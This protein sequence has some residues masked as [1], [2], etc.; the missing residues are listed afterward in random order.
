MAG[1]QQSLRPQTQIAPT[2]QARFETKKP[3]V[4]AVVFGLDD[5]LITHSY[6]T[7]TPPRLRDADIPDLLTELRDNGLRLFVASGY[8]PA[9]APGQDNP[10]LIKLLTDKGYTCTGSVTEGEHWKTGYSRPNLEDPE[11]SGATLLIPSATSPGN[12][13]L[14]KH[15]LME[16]LGI[17]PYLFEAI[18]SFPHERQS[19]M[20]P[21]VRSKIEIYERVRADTGISSERI[22]VVSDKEDERK[23]VE[24]IGIR[25]VHVK[26]ATDAVCESMEGEPDITLGEMLKHHLFGNGQP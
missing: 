21:Y 15:L 13:T 25:F 18:F 2:G 4:D 6:G 1:S 23:A 5:T 8:P 12:A 7:I 14:Q 20:E 11:D 3:L 22:L 17:D 19:T 16:E 26:R 9:S 24:G 10:G